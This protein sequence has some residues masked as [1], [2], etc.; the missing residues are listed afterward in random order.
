MHFAASCEIHAQCDILT[1]ALM[2]HVVLGLVAIALEVKM[3]LKLISCIV[4]RRFST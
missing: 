3:Q 4:V 2:Q 1:T